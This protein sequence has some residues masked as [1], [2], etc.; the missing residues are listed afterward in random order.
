[1]RKNLENEMKKNCPHVESLSFLGITV[2]PRTIRE[3]LDLVRDS[4]ACQRKSVIANHNLHSL[5]LFHRLPELRSFFAAA[6][7]THIDGMAMLLL[8]RIYGHRIQ[9]EQRVTY[10]D[11]TGPLMQCAVSENW[12]IFYLGSKPGVASIGAARWRSQYPGLRIRSTHGYFQGPDRTRQT[13][14]VIE[15]INAFKPDILMVGMGMPVQELWIQEHLS[16]LNASVILPVG[17]TIDYAA[18]AVRTPPRWSGRMGLE[19]AFRLAWEPN[20][21]WRRYLLEPVFILQLM[22]KEFGRNI[23]KSRALESPVE[24]KEQ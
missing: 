16:K 8:G 14:E 3:L 12:R 23:S 4:I 6:A 13:E 15:Q 7:C 19:W 17:A 21:L 1:M 18:A 22:M 10:V 5:Y 20:R 11:L 24:I 9:L 2:H